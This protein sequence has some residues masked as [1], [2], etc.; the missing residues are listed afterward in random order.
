MSSENLSDRVSGRVD[1]EPENHLHR[2]TA[3][4]QTRADSSAIHAAPSQLAPRLQRIHSSL[5]DVDLELID[6]LALVRMASG[7]QL[8]RL[9]WPTSPSGARTARRRLQRLTELRIMTRLHRQVGGVKGGSQGYTYAL[10]VNGQRIAQTRHHNTIRRPTPS[11]SFVD[12][13][14]AVTET[15]II[16]RTAETVE[17]LTWEPE[18]T[19][20]RSYTGPAGRSMTLRP[21]A[22][23]AWATGEWELSAFLEIDRAT[24]HPG[25]IARKADQYARYWQTG[26]EQQRPGVFPSVLWITP[27]TKRAQVL[28]TVLGQHDAAA[29]CTVITDED[30]PDFITNT[31]RKEEHP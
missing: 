18:P 21:D 31:P 28:R 20:W 26:Q 29:L 27:S 22:Y 30:M 25:R 5:T 7:S 10:D 23:A 11:D 15:Y 6:T 3:R 13:T 16:L 8:N 9:F 17:L 14:L 24:E 19:C 1:T 4:G 2:G 12:H